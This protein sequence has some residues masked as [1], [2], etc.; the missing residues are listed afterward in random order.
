MNIF[1]AIIRLLFPPKC[2]VCEKDLDFSTDIPY[3][4]K[5]LSELNK[6]RIFSSTEQTLEAVDS[7][8]VLFSYQSDSTRHSV[9]HLKKLFSPL[10][11]DFYRKTCLEFFEKNNII[12]HVDAVT[13]VKR[14]FTE[15]QKEGFDQS[16][17]MAK[18]ISETVNVPC[19]KALK[20]VKWS[21]KQRNLTPT[22]RAENVKGVF[23]CKLR[24]DGM[25][26]LLI[27]DVVTTGSTISECAKALKEMGAVE[28]HVL[29]FSS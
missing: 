17:K 28:V 22:E 29:T 10:F 12:N 15:K 20:R 8:Y 26:I 6:A 2:I 1:E 23:K 19:I 16:Y 11:A 18:I 14:R 13:F 27:D 25:K 7:F 9:Y 21:K 24:L 3:C 4:P 5:C